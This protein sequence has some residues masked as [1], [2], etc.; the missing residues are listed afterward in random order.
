LDVD[1]GESFDLA[2]RRGVRQDFVLDGDVPSETALGDRP[3]QFVQGH[4]AVVDQIHIT[5][6]AIEDRRR[7]GSDVWA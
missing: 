3:G 1:D 5:G 4:G 2:E 7:E 6:L